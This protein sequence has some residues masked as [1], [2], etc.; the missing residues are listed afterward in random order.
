MSI[1]IQEIGA[2]RF[3]QYGRIPSRFEVQSIL[4]VEVMGTGL[5]GFRLVEERVEK[6][7]VRDYDQNSEDNPARWAS[8]F[9]VSRWGIL[10]ATDDVGQPVGG[11]AVAVEPPIFPMGRFQRDDLA[12]L[13]DIRVDPEH[14]RQG[15]GSQLF[16]AAAGWAR[17]KGYGQLGIETD[18]SNVTACRFYTRQGCELGAIHRFGY[19]G[20]PEVAAYAMLLWYLEL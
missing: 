14:R 7:F 9:D 6:P 1:T 2:D 8:R 15:I 16:R 19:A 4:R 12:A 18:G 17:R 10:M 3:S 13:W 11:A 5:G 20:V